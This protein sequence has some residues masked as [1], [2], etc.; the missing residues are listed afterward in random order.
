MRAKRRAL[1]AWSSRGPAPRR[2]TKPAMHAIRESTKP[3]TLAQRV[4]HG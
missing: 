3:P 1:Q 2:P 4:S